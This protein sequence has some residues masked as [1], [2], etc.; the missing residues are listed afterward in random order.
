M[1]VRLLS[2]LCLILLLTA[3]SCDRYIDSQDPV[4]SLP[5]APATPINVE[6]TLNSESVTLNW[7]LR[8]SSGVNRFRIYVAEDT[9]LGYR[10][11]DSST[12]YQYTVENLALNR[13]YFFRVAAVDANG[14]EG[15]RSTAVSTV[16]SLLSITINNNDE[17]TNA[18]NV[19][20]Q[21]IANN[22]ISHVY[23][24]EDPNFA[25]ATAR[26][27]SSTLPFDLSSGDG[28]KTLYARFAF[29]DGAESGGTI[30]DSIILDTRAQID[31]VT[32]APS[33]T[34]FTS[35]DTILFYLGSGET[36]GEA[37]VSF[38]GNSGTRLYDDGNSGDL[39]ASDGVY[40]ARWIVPN[41]FTLNNEPPEGEFTD[42][43]GNT[44]VQSSVTPLNIFSTPLPVQLTVI[45]AIESYEINLNWSQAASS[46]FASYRVYRAASNSVDDT[47]PLV[48]TITNRNSVNFVDTTVDASTTY[49][50]R[51][52]VRNSLGQTAGSNVLS[53]T[54]S[55]NSNPTAV[56][57]AGVVNGEGN[58]VLTW[59]TSSD[60]DFSSYRIYRGN[61]SS[62]STNSSG[63]LVRIVT[64]KSTTTETHAFSGANPWYRVYVYDRQGSFTASDPIQVSN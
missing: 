53:A 10:L 47:S 4:R 54:T 44:K 26:A 42:A 28:S 41:D 14:L 45:E 24:S 1:S 25:G 2:L 62:G 48:A 38:S 50:Y 61:S 21:L 22:A 30:A 3:V 40:S 43:A 20:V 18:E 34:T 32:F 27:F 23:L 33:G 49:Y 6:L 63:D 39:V 15:K 37:R 9:T 57:L 5:A 64:N 17:Y 56:V 36:G 11:D 7:E 8:D 35:G 31:S 16:V 13:D 29:V 46:D 58:V 55:S 60:D 51:V 59:T 19:Q 12:A 52:Y